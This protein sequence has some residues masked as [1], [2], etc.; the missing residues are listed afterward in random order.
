MFVQFCINLRCHLHS[1][2]AWKWL[3]RGLSVNVF[4]DQNV[5]GFGSTWEANPSDHRTDG[6]LVCSYGY[7]TNNSDLHITI[8]S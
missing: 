3:S 4:I 6:R 2:A 5:E 8:R 1:D 7:N